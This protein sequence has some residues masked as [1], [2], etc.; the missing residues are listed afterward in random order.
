[1]SLLNPRT[2]ICLYGI[3]KSIRLSF[4]NNMTPSILLVPSN[5]LVS[6]LNPRAY[7]S[8]WHTNASLT[9]CHQ[10]YYSFPSI[11]GLYPRSPPMGLSLRVS[12]SNCVQLF[13]MRPS[14]NCVCFHSHVNGDPMDPSLMTKQQL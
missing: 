5:T 8:L 9:P 7:M 14:T 6:L 11:Q 12:Q 3:L 1:M 2:C 13:Y 10:G 4:S